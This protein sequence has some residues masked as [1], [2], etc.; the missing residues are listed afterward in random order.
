MIH[1]NDLLI[2]LQITSM[3]FDSIFHLIIVDTTEKM[4]I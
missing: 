3:R 2:N 1:E 4:T